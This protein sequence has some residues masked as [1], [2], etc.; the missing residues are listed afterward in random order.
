L[1]VWE[2]EVTH[3][4][5]MPH[6]HPSAPHRAAPID[7]A[8]A[9]HLLRVPEAAEILRCSDRQIRR[10]IATGRLRAAR[11]APAGSSRVLIPRD[12]AAN[13]IGASMEAA[14]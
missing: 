7:L 3:C 9:P 6:V 12:A 2:L 1:A 4:Q 10:L 11:I 5:G 13:L 14:G 8:D